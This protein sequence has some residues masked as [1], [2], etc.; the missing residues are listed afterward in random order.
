MLCTEGHMQGFPKN[1]KR[2][3]ESQE[4]EQEVWLGEIFYSVVGV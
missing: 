2:W 4:G 3:G 1:I